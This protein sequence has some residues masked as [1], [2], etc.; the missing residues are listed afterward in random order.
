MTC[1]R[2]TSVC[3]QPP[4]WNELHQRLKEAVLTDRAISPPPVPLILGGW[5]YSN[6]IQKQARWQATIA[7]AKHHGLSHLV[8][9]VPDEFMY[10]VSEQSLYEAGPFGGP[11]YLEWNF[12]SKPQIS[13]AERTAAIQILQSN[14]KTIADD[15]LGNAT[16]PLRLTGR[17]GRRLLV[18]VTS[19]LTPRWGSWT[20]LA[21]EEQKRRTFTALRVAVN[22]AV[23][24]LEI[25][26]ID[27]IDESPGS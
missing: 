10:F 24:P 11:M 27:F 20:T 2:K 14:W 8:D 18:L 9:N 21:R 3:P 26:H 16:R 1:P 23:F 6:N 13:S 12:D 17:K 25:D 15:E 7:W 5:A 22:R 19:N 4:Y